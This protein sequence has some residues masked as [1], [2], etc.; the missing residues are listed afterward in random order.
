MPSYKEEWGFATN[1]SP[2]AEGTFSMRS[3]S[4]SLDKFSVTFDD[5][6]AVANAGLIQPATLAQHLG[7]RELFDSYLEPRAFRLRPP[8]GRTSHVAFPEAP[9][10]TVVTLE[11]LRPGLTSRLLSTRRTRG[12]A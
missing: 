8:A 3:S 7:L 9:A 12:R 11:T 5:D 6:H 4:H 10:S 1:P 2:Q